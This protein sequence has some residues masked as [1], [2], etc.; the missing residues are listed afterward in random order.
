M[1]KTYSEGIMT[2][3]D[4]GWMKDRLHPLS[5]IPVVA[6][7]P[8]QQLHIM[9]L[10]R[11]VTSAD[12]RQVTPKDVDNL[13]TQGVTV[14]EFKS[15]MLAMQSQN[16]YETVLQTSR[17]DSF[18]A[19]ATS[20]VRDYVLIAEAGLRGSAEWFFSVVRAITDDHRGICARINAAKAHA[21]SGVW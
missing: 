1:R 20:S 21:A 15:A 5:A 4:P 3:V 17:D 11:R 14:E 13:M 2:A 12:L 7:P 16:M 8:S 19:A 6:I 9:E 10:G 18:A